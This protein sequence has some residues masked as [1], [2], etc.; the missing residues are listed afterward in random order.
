[1]MCYWATQ[2]ETPWPVTFI[3]AAGSSSATVIIIPFARLKAKGRPPLS[4]GTRPKSLTQ[5]SPS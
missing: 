1:M 5:R 2:L 4:S 3:R